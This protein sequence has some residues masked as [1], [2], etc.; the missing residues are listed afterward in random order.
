MTN[1]II[2]MGTLKNFINMKL[3]GNNTFITII[4]GIYYLLSP[5]ICNATHG[6]DEVGIDSN[7]EEIEK[8]P[9]TPPR[10]DQPSHSVFR[11][12]PEIR[13]QILSP[14]IKQKLPKQYF[15]IMD[16]QLGDL[17]YG[18]ESSRKEIRSLLEDRPNIK[19]TTVDNYN[20]VFI[21]LHDNILEPEFD[22]ETLL[23]QNQ[24]GFSD[25]ELKLIK[26]YAQF[27]N[28]EYKLEKNLLELQENDLFF[29]NFKRKS[30]KSAIIFA[31]LRKFRIH[32]VLDSIDYDRFFKSGRSFTESELLFLYRLYLINK[33]NISHVIFYEKGE[34]VLPPW[35]Q[36]H[37]SLEYW[38]DHYRPK[39]EK[40]RKIESS[41]IR[42]LIELD[43]KM[44]TSQEGGV[45]RKSTEVP[46]VTEVPSKK[47]KTIED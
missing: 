19:L 5:T 9:V 11:T 41:L 4:F 35:E 18:L 14:D 45:K 16:F 39:L 27:L 33:N 46:E 20:K 8:T 21:N 34:K 10:N 40:I 42:N 32:F 17:L 43:G 44:P 12:P 31:K 25:T 2:K 3:F 26:D 22:L 47:E 24:E 30:C 6:L 37:G 23:Q 29:D 38:M 15:D 36:G 7:V 1:L 13:H 28:K